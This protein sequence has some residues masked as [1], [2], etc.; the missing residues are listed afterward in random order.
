MNNIATIYSIILMLYAQSC[1]FIFSNLDYFVLA[2]NMH[3]IISKSQETEEMFK[4]IDF[5]IHAI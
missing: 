5:N 2:R 4:E 1:K 3:D